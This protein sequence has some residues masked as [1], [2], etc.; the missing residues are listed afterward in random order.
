M[1]K[2]KK[3]DSWIVKRENRRRGEREEEWKKK[4]LIVKSGARANK[5]L[6]LKA[7]I[8]RII[9]SEGMKIRKY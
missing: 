9:K 2:E 4:V 6:E 1:R 8:R 3:V 7:W 5:R